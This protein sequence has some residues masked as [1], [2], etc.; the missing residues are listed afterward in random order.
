MLCPHRDGPHVDV[1]CPHR[2]DGGGWLVTGLAVALREVKM[3]GD[4]RSSSCGAP[5]LFPHRRPLGFA[6]RAFWLAGVVVVTCSLVL[7]RPAALLQTDA[8]TLADTHQSS[9]QAA[10]CDFFGV[11]LPAAG[12]ASDR[13]ETD[14]WNVG[15]LT[16]RLAPPPRPAPSGCRPLA[17]GSRPSSAMTSLVQSGIRL[18]I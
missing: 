1:L 15:S 6:S 14:D 3:E 11:P 9:V 8:Q 7:Q 12:D 2:D 4:F 13:L 10:T 5:A 16:G 17:R 18:Q